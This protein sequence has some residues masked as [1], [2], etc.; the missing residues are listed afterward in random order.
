MNIDLSSGCDPGNGFLN[1]FINK[2]PNIIEL[3]LG[4]GIQGE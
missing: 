4:K 3:F 2:V 1:R